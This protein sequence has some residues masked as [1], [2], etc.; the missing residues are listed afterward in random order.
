VRKLYFALAM[1]SARCDGA[2]LLSAFRKT[3]NL[4]AMQRRSQ[5]Q[6]RGLKGLEILEMGAK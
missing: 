5:G 3:A 4:T 1:A 2:R 6:D